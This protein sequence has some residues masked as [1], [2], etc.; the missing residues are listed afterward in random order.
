[1]LNGININTIINLKMKSVYTDCML[2]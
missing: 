2:I 1:M